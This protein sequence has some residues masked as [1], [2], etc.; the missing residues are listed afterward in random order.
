[1]QYYFNLEEIDLTQFPVIS[2]RKSRNIA[3]GRKEGNVILN[4]S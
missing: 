3:Q 1:M 4:G 2:K